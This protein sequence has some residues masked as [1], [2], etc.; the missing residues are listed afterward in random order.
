VPSTQRASAGRLDALGTIALDQAQ[1][2]DAG[3]KALLGMRPRAQ[4]NVNQHSG[5]P[6]DCLGFVS[7]A[8]V[9]PVAIAPM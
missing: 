7:D 2:S 9:G 6:T 8:F 5:I 1:D 4:D 3:A